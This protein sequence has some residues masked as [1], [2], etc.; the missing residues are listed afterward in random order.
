[1]CRVVDRSQTR[2]CSIVGIGGSFLVLRSRRLFDL[3]VFRHA[4]AAEVVCVASM[5]CSTPPRWCRT[6]GASI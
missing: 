3:I 4:D 5:S 6:D 2:V 1:M